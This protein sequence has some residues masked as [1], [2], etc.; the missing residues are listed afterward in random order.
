MSLTCNKI[1][2][3][4]G[5]IRGKD[6]F[7]WTG[8]HTVNTR[9]LVNGAIMLAIYLVLFIIYNIGLVP[10]L[11]IVLLPIPFIVHYMRTKVMRDVIWLFV[12]A[13]VGSFLL[14]S[15]FGLITTLLF[16]TTGL[17]LAYGI[18]KEWT[19]SSR[20]LNASIAYVIMFPLA[21][22]FLTGLSMTDS[23]GDLLSSIT[24]MLESLP[25]ELGVDLEAIMPAL[26]QMQM[27]LKM[28]IPT[29]LLLQGLMLVFITDRLTSVILKRMNMDDEHVNSFKAFQLGKPLAM[30]FLITQLVGV[31]ITNTTLTV[32]VVN[33]IML[34]TILF[35][36]QG[37]IVINL[38]C[39][40]RGK[41]GLG[42][43]L[44]ILAM[45]SGMNIFIVMFGVADALFN[46]RQRLTITH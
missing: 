16:G 32:I 43:A 29:I 11:I 13:C 37:I 41:K 1:L 30:T 10:G 15:I 6:R 45:I 28:L 36:V 38:L 27:L 34:L 5:I 40:A 3:I 12:G 21:L 33:I 44:T 39:R 24:L 19:Y 4:C 2:H 22:Q 35:M 42:I 46:Y 17:I 23:I 9:S 18:H 20:I 8:G 14:G 25:K 26:E 7:N 31:F